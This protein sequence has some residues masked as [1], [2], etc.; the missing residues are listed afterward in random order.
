MKIPTINEA[1][2]IGVLVIA[3]QTA[4]CQGTIYTSRSIFE[5]ALISSTAITF[6]ELPVTYP[7][8]TGEFSVTTSGVTFTSP[9]A[10]L[11]V[12]GPGGL[13]P[14]P[15]DGNYLWHFDGGFPVTVQLPAGVTALGADFSGGIEPQSSFNATLTVNLVGGGSYAHTFSG[16]RGSWTF[17]GVTYPEEIL[18][19]IFDDGGTFMPGTHEEMF[20][21][22]TFGFVPEPRSIA[23]LMLGLLLVLFWNKSPRSQP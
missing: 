19:V 4:F 23:V 8:G 14:I 15:G 6:E 13:Y 7:L 12:T 3:T 18:S 5:A 9:G 10:R 22:V 11:F 1:T 2:L 16:L 21:N 20:D 17:F